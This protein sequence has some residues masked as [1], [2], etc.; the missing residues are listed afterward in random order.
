MN[1]YPP[2]LVKL[3]RSLCTLPG[4]GQK[5][6]ERLSL[7][8]LHAPEHEVSAIV[9]GIADVKKK[10]RVCSLCFNLT[11]EER[12]RICQDPRRDMSVICVVESPADL[13]AIEKAQVYSGVYHI[14]GGALSPIDGIGPSDIRIAELVK[15]ADPHV[16]QEIILATRTTVEGQATASYI[17][18]HLKQLPIR[19]SRIA[20]GVPMGGDF[21]YVDSLTIG[22]AMERRSDF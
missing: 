19:I 8:L 21:Q 4:I 9:S 2:A 12:C 15:R 7:H 1:H 11:Q 6:S 20:S 14:L 3:I 5:T 13:A 18:T 22:Q 17:Q 10:V 16:V